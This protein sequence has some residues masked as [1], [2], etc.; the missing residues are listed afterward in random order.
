MLETNNNKAGGVLP[1]W[2]GVIMRTSTANLAGRYL[3]FAALVATLPGAANAA[4]YY[5]PAFDTK[6]SGSVCYYRTYSAAFLKKNPNVKLTAISLERRSSVSDSVPNS[7]AR[8]ALT[9]QA[10]TKDENYTAIALCK[11][12]GSTVACTVENKG[13][14]FTVMKAGKGVVI[15]TRR[16]AIDGFYKNLLIASAKDKPTRSFTLTGSGKKSCEAV[17]N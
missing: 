10:T 12:Q 9:F 15:K 16:I 5:H 14:S 3:L 1:P 4:T 13:G 17:F 2:E 11:A 6:G 7:K 8:F